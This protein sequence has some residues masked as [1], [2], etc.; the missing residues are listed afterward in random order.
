MCI[1][2]TEGIALIE[3]MSY[4][5]EDKY[6]I[7]KYNILMILHLSGMKY[8]IILEIEDEMK[9]TKKWCDRRSMIY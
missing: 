7:S 9:R 6:A 4:H 5:L 3:I 2:L 1:H 8:T